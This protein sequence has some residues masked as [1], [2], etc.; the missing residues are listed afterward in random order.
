MEISVTKL[1]TLNLGT[2]YLLRLIFFKKQFGGRK[3]RGGEHMLR[4][5]KTCYSTGE[6]P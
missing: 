3:G 5:A 6:K 4:L 1:H 2:S